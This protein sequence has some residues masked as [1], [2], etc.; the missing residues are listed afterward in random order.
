MRI[1]LSLSMLFTAAVLS[2]VPVVKNGKSEYVIVISPKAEQAVMRAAANDLRTYIFKAT[3]AKLPIVKE[4]QRGKRPAFM[5]GYIKVDKP[6]GFVV[7]TQGRDIHI[8]GNDT[9]GDVYNNHWANGARVGTWFGVADFLEKQLGIRW[10][11]PGPMGEYVPPKRA[12]WDVPELNYA[13]APRFEMRRMGYQ[14]RKGMPKKQVFENQLWMRRN[15]VGHN[16][17]WCAWHSWLHYLKKEDYFDK[18]PEYFAYVGGRRLGTYSHGHGLQICT[19]NPKALDQMAAN[20]IADIKKRKRPAML[21]LSPNDGGQM[22]ECK[23]CQ[24][25]DDGVRPDG[26]RI[27]TTR[28]MTY[29]NEMA[30]RITKHYPNQTMGMYAYSFY[31]EGVSKVKV[32]PNVVIEEVLNDSGLSY[33]NPKRRAS[34]LQNLK[35]WRKV[36]NKLFYYATP[37]GMGGLELP[38]CQFKNISMLYDNLY[39]ADVT[40]IDMN[41]GT[42]YGAAAL[43]NYFYLKYAWGSIKNKEKFY[44]ETLRD[45]YGKIA[46]PVVRGYFDDIEKRMS[47]YV[48][49]GLKENRSLGYVPRYPGVLTKVYPGLAEKWLPKLKAVA[50]KTT[51]KGQKARLQ[52]AITN[53]EY[54]QITVKLYAIASKLVLAAKPDARLAAEALKLTNA[55]NAYLKKMGPLPSNTPSNTAGTE[56]TYRLPFDANVFSFMMAAN[57]R[58]NGSTTRINAAPVMDGKLSDAI[59]KN[60]KPMRIELDKDTANPFKVGANVYL[61]RYKGDLYIGFH[62]EEPLMN[63]NMD[64]GRLP[65]SPVWDEN[66]IDLFFATPEKQVYQLV[67][68]SL[69]TIRSFKKE[70]KINTPWDAKAVVKT[71]RGKDFWSAELK[72][73]LSSMTKSKDF[74]GDIWGMNFCRARRTVAP[75][76]YSCWS[77]TFGDFHRPERFGRIVIK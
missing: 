49:G 15:R 32:H 27:M 30:K 61:T 47:D 12:D 2:A 5:L 20:M 11:M 48:Q 51:D 71:F 62:C 66:C 8:S 24:A 28:M 59:W 42:S 46:A 16:N 23:N 55:R 50:A 40:G 56:R 1:L 17:S 7:K 41:N 45:C 31:V 6:E 38:C 14:T 77:P 54:C 19:T 73:P 63:K 4:S 33:Y 10:F 57:A 26:S 39:A 58:K 18:H 69:G 65:T 43:N 75:D 25:L 68:N 72:L 21:P 44:A 22:C 9:P 36:L 70:G 37:E 29:A 76:Q 60:V 64:S 13:D 35:A 3:G 52:V 67:F 74:L 53:L 34:H